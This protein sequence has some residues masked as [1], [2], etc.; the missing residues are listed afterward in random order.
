MKRK[1]LGRGLDALLPEDNW[2]GNVRDIP[3]TEIDLNPDQPRKSFDQEA[4]AQLADSIRQLGLLQPILVQQVKGRYQIIAGERRFRAAR[5]AGLQQLPCIEKDF[6]ADEKLLAALIENLQ[7]EDLNPMEEAAAIRSVMDRLQLTQEQAAEKLGKSRS[8]LANVLRLLSLPEGVAALVR[9]GQLSEG[10][11]RALAGLKDAAR[12]QSLADRVIS[13][14][15]SV[16][17]LEQLIAEPAK[18]RATTRAELAP[19]LSDF[20]QQLHRATGL[21]TSIVGNMNKGRL[22]ISYRSFEELEALYEAMR[23]VIP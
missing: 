22:T 23:Q 3:I 8:A 17:A 12:Q 19:E 4:L 20:A 6:D 21:R 9:S 14:G 2:Q 5:L 7:R 10:H 11:G 16:R 18:P 15:L 13:Q 1:G